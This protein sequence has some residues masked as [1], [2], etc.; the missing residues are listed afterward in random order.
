MSGTTEIV[1]L[2]EW[3]TMNSR[4]FAVRTIRHILALPENHL[5]TSALIVF[6]GW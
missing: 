3:D 2:A 4:V 5:P 1:R 6:E